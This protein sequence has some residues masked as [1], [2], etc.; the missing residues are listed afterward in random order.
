VPALVG[1]VVPGQKGAIRP[2]AGFLLLLGEGVT[3]G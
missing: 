3:C 1:D 2:L